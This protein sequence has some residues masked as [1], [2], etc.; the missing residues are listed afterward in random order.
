MSSARID[1]AV[2]L[3][4]KNVHGKRAE[5]EARFFFLVCGCIGRRRD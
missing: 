4:V 1:A 5:D 2:Q 3:D